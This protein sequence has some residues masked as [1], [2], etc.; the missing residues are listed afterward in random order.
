MLSSGVLMILA[1][2][3]GSFPSCSGSLV[4]FMYES[5]WLMCDMLFF[6]DTECIV[7]ISDP[8]SWRVWGTDDCFLLKV[9]HVDIGYSWRCWGAHCTS[10]G[11]HIELSLELEVGLVQTEFQ[12]VSYLGW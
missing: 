8:D 7:H 1:S 4:N 3:K 6:D 2:R 12:E 5:C 11:L 10:M 9:F